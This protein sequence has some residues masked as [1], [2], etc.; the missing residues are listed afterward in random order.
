MSTHIGLIGDIH[1]TPAPLAEALERFAAAGVERILCPGD[2]A[3][4]GSG[5]ARCVS[6]L[7]A[8]G[9]QAVEGNHDRW[10]LE[11]H[12]GESDA[13][14]RYFKTLPTHRQMEIAGRSLYLVH[15]SP[16]DSDMAAIKLL[17][18]DGSVNTA[19]RAFWEERLSG[20]AH[21]LLIVGHVHQTYAM[22]LG[23]TLVINPGSSVFN[24]SAAILTLPKMEVEWLALSGEAI[25]PTWNWGLFVRSGGRIE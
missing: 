18:L 1:A 2:I 4:Y 24:H 5:L 15:A 17:D 12:A 23:D 16:P 7:E 13:A 6:L 19:E 10:Y 11:A 9:V 25:Q 22:H 8:C 21:E 14:S 20:F 3:G